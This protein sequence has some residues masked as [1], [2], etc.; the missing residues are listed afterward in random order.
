[1]EAWEIK[2]IFEEDPN[3]ISNCQQYYVQVDE[4]D[5]KLGEAVAAEN[6]SNIDLKEASGS[7]DD[8]QRHFS[9]LLELLRVQVPAR[10]HRRLEPKIDY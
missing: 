3:D 5:G 6:N 9:K 8:D 1:L 10:T 2:E 7:G 4:R